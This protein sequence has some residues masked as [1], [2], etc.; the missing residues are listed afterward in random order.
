MKQFVVAAALVAVVSTLPAVA[1]ARTRE[2]IV[3][4]RTLAPNQEYGAYLERIGARRLGAANQNIVMTIDVATPLRNAAALSAYARESNAPGSLYYRQWLTPAKIAD[5]F[6]TPAAAYAT[7]AA[8]FSNQ[9]LAVKTWTPRN[10]I[11]VTGSL[12][13]LGRALGTTFDLYSIRSRYA[14][15]ATRF[16]APL[17][18]PSLPGNI[19]VSGFGHLMTLPTKLRDFMITSPAQ[20]INS[21]FSN[22]RV[23]GASPT[24]L[25]GAFDYTGAYEAGFTGAGIN[26]GII[27]TGPISL[28]DVP[29]FRAIY[30]VPG[31]STVTIVPA[32]VNGDQTPPPVT[33]PCPSS[34]SGSST[35]PDA[36]CDP[37][38]VEAQLD[39]EQ[40][41]GLGIDANV[42]FYLAYNGTSCEVIGVAGT[43]VGGTGSGQGLD[44]SDDEIE[45]AATDD[46]ADILSLSYGGCE[47]LEN[48]PAIGALTLNPGGDATGN[49]PTM[50]AMLAA[51]GVAVF[52]STGD[53]G[54]AGCQPFVETGD[55]D[56]PVVEYP[57]SDPNVVGVGGTTTPIGA[58]GRLLG[59]ITTWGQQTESGGGEGGGT[60][61]DFQTPPF[62]KGVLAACTMRCIPDVVLDADPFTGAAVVF[63]TIPGV[64]A[65]EEPVGG[66]SQSAPDMAAMWSLVLSACKV[67]PSCTG[68]YGS[69]VSDPVSGYTP[70]AGVPAYRLGNPNYLIYKLA[71]ASQ[72]A[73]YHSVFYDIVYGNNAVPPYAAQLAFSEGVITNEYSEGVAAGSVSAG[74]GDD[75]ATGLGAPFARALIKYIVGV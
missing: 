66:T 43:C 58:D 5:N 34:N 48:L 50:F 57:A 47:L 44:L 13:K 33:G 26:L 15:T 28:L 36:G 8:Y 55:S 64:Q 20:P 24:Q 30:N 65:E 4:P 25:A 19:A 60:S 31:S 53:S 67:T 32:S 6:G 37:E 52:A 12:A 21:G 7:T 75:V 45:Q 2:V 62:Q 9:G 71:A 74:T 54:S 16:I 23:N 1:D 14:R 70:P 61:M 39:T 3:S 59:P 63:N 11:T 56:L 35:A 38:D 41:A 27:G 18:K 40:A 49:D 22:A 51:E 69:N 10:V 68:N 29:N 46:R 17:G 72:S 73:T 42:L